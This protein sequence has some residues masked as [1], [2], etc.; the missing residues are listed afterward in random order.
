MATKIIALFLSILILVGCAVDPD[1]RDMKAALK[2]HDYVQ[3]DKIMR[4]ERAKIIAQNRKV[5]DQLSSLSCDL[6]INAHENLHNN[7]K[8]AGYLIEA[9]SLKLGIGDVIK[10]GVHG[11]ARVVRACKH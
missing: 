8:A 9:V 7:E 11:N 3:A 1:K 6:V 4:H 2:N 5:F 10:R